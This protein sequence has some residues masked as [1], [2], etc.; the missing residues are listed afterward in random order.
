[1]TQ[2]AEH[3]TKTLTYP[4]K[5]GEVNLRED[6]LISFPKGVLG[7]G[8]CT[9]FGLSALPNTEESPLLVL[10]CI[11]DPT[12]TFLVGA[13]EV[14]GLDIDPADRQQALSDSSMPPADTQFM[15]I[16]NMKPFGRE[17][18]T[19]SYY[20]TANLRAPLLIDTVSRLGQQVVLHN[21]EYSTQQ[22]I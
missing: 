8:E 9:V 15:L 19:D 3:T 1:M 11:N 7:F 20:L 2:L 21:K 22:K 5:Y 4:T 10:Q 18:E 14:L 16:L 13:P 17:E 12:I 6:R